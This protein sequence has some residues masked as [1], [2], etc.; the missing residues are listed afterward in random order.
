MICKS[1]PTTRLHVHGLHT[2]PVEFGNACNSAADRKVP[3]PGLP[4]RGRVKAIRAFRNWTIPCTLNNH[5]AQKHALRHSGY[6]RP[7]PQPG[8]G[9]IAAR[10][11]NNLARREIQGHES[12]NKIAEGEGVAQTRVATADKERRRRQQA[13]CTISAAATIPSESNHRVWLCLAQRVS[14][15]ITWTRCSIRIASERH[16]T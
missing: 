5:S 12:I 3:K 6:C 13:C 7:C 15:H 10:Q 8:T 1:S 14:A 9:F 4:Q 16:I 11:R 2:L